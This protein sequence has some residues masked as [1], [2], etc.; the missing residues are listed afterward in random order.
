MSSRGFGIYIQIYQKNACAIICSS[1]ILITYFTKLPHPCIQACS[2]RTLPPQ[3]MASTRGWLPNMAQAQGHQDRAQDMKKRRAKV[4]LQWVQELEL[5]L[6]FVQ[7]PQA[8]T[9]ESASSPQPTFSLTSRC[10]VS[11]QPTPPSFLKKS[12]QDQTQRCVHTSS[13]HA[14]C[15]ETRR[16]SIS[17][18]MFKNLDKDAEQPVFEYLSGNSD[19]NRFASGVCYGCWRCISTAMVMLKCSLS[20]LRVRWDAEI[21][22]WSGDENSLYIFVS[23]LAMPIGASWVRKARGR[24]WKSSSQ[25]CHRVTC[26]TDYFKVK[27]FGIKTVYRLQCIW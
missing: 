12:S 20:C 26:L 21:D 7:T 8:A 18:R 15:A 17:V 23:V 11:E 24:R 3:G 1:T 10:W 6:D 16:R 27:G 25:P 2:P 4:K 5:E 14:S 9:Q 19:C 13:A 22:V